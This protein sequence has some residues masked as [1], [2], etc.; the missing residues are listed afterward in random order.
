VEGLLRPVVL[1]V[2]PDELV[3]EERG[4]LSVPQLVQLPERGHV[5]PCPVQPEPGHLQ[6]GQHGRVLNQGHAAE[7]HLGG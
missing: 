3:P 4:D 5:P 2:L 7:V 6:L 1:R